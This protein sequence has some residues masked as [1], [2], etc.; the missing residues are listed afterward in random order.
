[1]YKT[2]VGIFSDTH[3]NLDGLRQSA[4]TAK[5]LGATTLI[6]LGD[7]YKDGAVLFEYSNEVFRVPGLFEPEYKEP[8][9]PRRFF[10]EISG[11]NIFITH[12]N[13]QEEQDL[14]EDI[15]PHKVAIENQ[16]DIYLYGH[17]HL[18]EAVIKG[19]ALFLNPGSLKYGDNRSR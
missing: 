12:S 15:N 3:R 14:P 7:S 11:F 17:S 18:Y 1:M 19:D 13:R 8:G 4:E 9:I 6:H 2:I 10:M 5:S 16:S